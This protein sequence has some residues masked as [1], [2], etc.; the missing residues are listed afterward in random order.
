MNYFYLK[1]EVL[2][3]FLKTLSFIKHFLTKQTIEQG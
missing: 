2:R 3:E 1:L